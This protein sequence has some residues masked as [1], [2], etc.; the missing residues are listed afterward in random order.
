MFLLH[1]ITQNLVSGQVNKQL[2]L[3]VDTN[4]DDINF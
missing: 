3:I 4:I 2:G 1:P